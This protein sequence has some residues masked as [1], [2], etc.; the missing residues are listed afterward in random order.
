MKTA[1]SNKGRTARNGI[2]R[3]LRRSRR[4]QPRVLSGCR[5]PLKSAIQRELKGINLD[6]DLTDLKHADLS[7][8]FEGALAVDSSEPVFAALFKCL[9]RCTYNG[10][11]ITLATFE[12][13]DARQDYYDIAV[14]CVRVNLSPFFSRLSAMLERLPAI[15]SAARKSSSA[16]KQ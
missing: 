13:E 3:T 12:P 9:L 10:H 14:A 2:N 11:K 6:L 1:K 4:N 16:M 8:L 5:G 15:K 7:A